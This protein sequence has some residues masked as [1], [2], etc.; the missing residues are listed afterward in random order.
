MDRRGRRL[1]DLERRREKFPVAEIH[2]R[3]LEPR[4]CAREANVSA[5]GGGGSAGGTG[6]KRRHAAISAGWL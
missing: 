2:S 3:S 6:A 1:Q 4:Q 5:G